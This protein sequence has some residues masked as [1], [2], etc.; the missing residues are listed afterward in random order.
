M[1]L[2]PD[3][4]FRP[5][6]PADLNAIWE[7]ASSWQRPGIKQWNKEQIAEELHGGKGLAGI[8]ATDKL[9][10]FILYREN[11]D[12]REILFLA[13]KKEFTRLGIMNQ[14]LK[15]LAQ[16]APLRLEVHQ[17]N[18]SARQCY[19]NCGFKEVGSRPKYYRDGGAAILYNY[20]E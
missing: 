20:P 18:L 3:I 10:A 15:H 2:P 5:V 8:L 12:H 11:V 9:V 14:L 6:Q 19:I 17:D 16:Q 1:S 7:I 13:T 4:S